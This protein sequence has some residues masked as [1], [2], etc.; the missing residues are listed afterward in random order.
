VPLLVALLVVQCNAFLWCDFGPACLG[1]FSL[2]RFLSPRW[3][4]LRPKTRHKKPWA[5]GWQA[6]SHPVFRFHVHSFF[7]FRHE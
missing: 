2:T 5:E 7:P 6:T 4:I 1:S 3:L